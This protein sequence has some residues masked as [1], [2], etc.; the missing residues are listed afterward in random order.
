MFEN[1][2]YNLM[3][4]A[5]IEHTSLWRIKNEYIKDAGNSPDSKAFWEK[6]VKD[7]EEHIAELKTLVKEAL[8]K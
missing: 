8:N 4:Q 2:L 1:N 5:T 3:M 7:K 6:M